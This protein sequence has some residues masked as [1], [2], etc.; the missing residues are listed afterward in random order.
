MAMRSRPWRQQYK[1]AVALA[2]RKRAYFDTKNSAHKKRRHSASGL[3]TTEIRKCALPTSSPVAALPSHGLPRT[4]RLQR[5]PDAK[6]FSCSRSDL[7]TQC[8]IHFQYVYHVWTN[9]SGGKND[10][11]QAQHENKWLFF[12]THAGQ[13]LMMWWVWCIIACQMSSCGV[14]PETTCLFVSPTHALIAV[15][16]KIHGHS[17]CVSSV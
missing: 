7:E 5:C 8:V 11:D 17:T 4:E 6:R 9:L 2:R 1:V 3:R 13:K 15:H 10:I 12:S 16:C 14:T